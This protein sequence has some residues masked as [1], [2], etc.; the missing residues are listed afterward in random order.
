VSL[1]RDLTPEK[2]FIFRITHIN[3]VPWI[4]N[5]GVHCKNSPVR[6]PNFVNIGNTDLIA[7]RTHRIVPIGSNRTLADYIPFYFTPRSPMLYNIRTGHGGITQRPNSEIVTLVT[8]LNR[9]EE[10]EVEFAFT[11][12]HAYLTTAS[13]HD[14]TEELHCIDW[15]ILQDSDFQRDP[16][17]PGKLERYQAEALVYRRLAVESLLGIATHNEAAKGEVEQMI[18]DADQELQVRVRPAWYFR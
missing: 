8:S 6:D 17:D 14:S 7:K 15:R 13:Y 9:L 16:E 5:N 10:Q 3:N 11:D 18:R 12:R 4:L 2:A 1:D